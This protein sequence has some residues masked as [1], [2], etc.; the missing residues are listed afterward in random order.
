MVINISFGIPN[1]AVIIFELDTMIGM[2]YK[3]AYKLDAMYKCL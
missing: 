3:P 2:A 1:K